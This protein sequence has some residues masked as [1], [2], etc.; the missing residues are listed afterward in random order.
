MKRLTYILKL[1]VIFIIFG[2]FTIT[3]YAS[4][5]SKEVSSFK[6]SITK[7]LITYKNKVIFSGQL[8]PAQSG[9]TVTLYQKIIGT[10]NYTTASTTITNNSGGFSFKIMPRDSVFLKAGWTGDTNYEAS[11]SQPLRVRVKAL[12]SIYQKQKKVALHKKAYIFGS[13]SPGHRN[14][15]IWLQY[16]NGKRWKNVKNTII[17]SHSRYGFKITLNQLMAHK[18]R[19]KFYD[20]DHSVSYSKILKISVYWPNP[21]GVSK[22]F[23][24]YIVVVKNK[25]R[26]YLIQYGN[27]TKTFPVVVG[28]PSTKTPAAYWKIGE[29]NSRSWGSVQGPLVLRLYSAGHRTRYG[30]HGTNHEELLG[31]WPRGYSHGC[32][33]MHNR[34]VLWLSSKVPIGTNVR[35]M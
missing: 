12:I 7:T 5:S 33:R 31:R 24:K 2:S 34:D 14:K 15:R 26:L 30:I 4:T 21:F 1:S 20:A 3:S 22:K 35:T 17:N 10:N 9:A 25:Y 6:V 19:V 16:L 8:S 29:K 11:E 32:I 13:V 27:I 28:K 23:S 18:F